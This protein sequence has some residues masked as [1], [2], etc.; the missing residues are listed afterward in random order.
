MA[1]T[2]ALLIRQQ[3]PSQR[4]IGDAIDETKAA[5]HAVQQDI[6][7]IKGVL[8]PRDVLSEVRDSIETAFWADLTLHTTG[9]RE[10]LTAQVAEFMESLAKVFQAKFDSQAHTIQQQLDRHTTVLQ[11]VLTSVQ[12]TIQGKPAIPLP[13]YG[14][15]LGAR[16]N[17]ML[18]TAII[19]AQR[20]AVEIW[21]FTSLMVCCALA[22]IA[23]QQTR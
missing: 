18:R 6:H 23:Y 8:S 19:R 16:L 14:Q 3:L 13:V 4:Q 20:V 9:E 12:D 17:A 15:S 5:L 22:V 1:E 10:V 2:Y 21:P 11:A 7:N